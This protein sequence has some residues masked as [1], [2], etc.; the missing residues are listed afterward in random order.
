VLVVL[1]TVALI[2]FL[3]HRDNPTSRTYTA[4]FLTNGQV[5]FGHI[6]DLDEKTVDLTD[7]FYLQTTNDLTAAKDKNGQAN[8]Q[9]SLVKL[10]EELHGPKDAMSINRQQVLFWEELQESGKVV[11]AINAYH[12]THK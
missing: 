1:L 12:S 7:V 8:V 2:F 9:L 10:G 3:I 4:V 11:Q 5:Y 6:K